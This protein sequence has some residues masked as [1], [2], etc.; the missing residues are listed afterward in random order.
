[1]K[2]SFK[3]IPLHAF[4]TSYDQRGTASDQIRL[5]ERYAHRYHPD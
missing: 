3:R 5:F 4:D 2:R 1:M